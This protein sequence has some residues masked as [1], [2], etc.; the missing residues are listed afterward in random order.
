MLFGL[1]ALQFVTFVMGIPALFRGLF[2]WLGS[3]K[4]SASFGSLVAPP[5]SFSRNYFV[6][7]LCAKIKYCCS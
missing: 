5:F 7:I 1:T 3:R 4:R 6:I 2:L